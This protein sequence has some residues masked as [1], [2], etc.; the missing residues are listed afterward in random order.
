ML[1]LYLLHLLMTPT[2]SIDA[3]S[4]TTLENEYVRATRNAAP[5]APASPSACGERVLVALGPI[6]FDQY[7]QTRGM[8]RGE[9]AVFR[10]NESYTAPMTGDYVEI[11]IKPEHPPVQPPRVP[12]PPGKNELLYDG[13][14]FFV[15]E[16]RLV[17]GDTRP[18]HSHS[19]RVVIVLNDTRLQ[20]R[21]DD[22]P[23]RTCVEMADDV[24]FSGPV[25]HTVKTIGEKPLHNIVIELKP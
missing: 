16:E 4:A 22:Q 24:R 17:R 14:S 12:R 5:C 3:A 21:A 1:L 13:E 8:G 7:G 18:R 23:E 19:Q 11:S 15:F 2:R 10:W 9:I 20:L 25:T 6:H